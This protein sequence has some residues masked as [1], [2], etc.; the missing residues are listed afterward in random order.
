VI[1]G[2]ES[3]MVQRRCD[4]LG[5][6]LV[7]QNIKDKDHALGDILEHTG[8]SAWEIAYMGDDVVDLPVIMAVGL[9]CSPSD[10]SH[11]VRQR[12]DLVTDAPGGGGAARELVFFVLQAQG[13]LEGL[14]GRYISS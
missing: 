5:I 11:E 1:T 6:K 3:T 8:R 14:M 13:L 10:A 7:F 9:G 4:E 2:R 12:S